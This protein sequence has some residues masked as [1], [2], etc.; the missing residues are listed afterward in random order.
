MACGEGIC[1]TGFR[2]GDGWQNRA[3]PRI[4]VIHVSQ[5]SAHVPTWLHVCPYK[6]SVIHAINGLVN[7]EEVVQLQLAQLRHPD[8]DGLASDGAYS[9][10]TACFAVVACA[11]T[12]FSPS[13]GLKTRLPV[14]NATATGIQH[15]YEE[16]KST[17]PN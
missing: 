12:A 13:L 2:V 11:F 5:L 15:A 4:C 16:K 1:Y 14:L 9:N 10:A 17:L 6:D 8:G 3:L 7:S